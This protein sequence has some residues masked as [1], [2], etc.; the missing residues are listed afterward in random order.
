MWERKTDFW[1]LKLRDQS[2]YDGID[3]GLPPIKIIVILRLNESLDEIL[4]IGVN[5]MVTRHLLAGHLCYDL[6]NFFSC[7]YF[8]WGAHKRCCLCATLTLEEIENLVVRPVQLRWRWTNPFLEWI[9][10][11]PFFFWIL[12]I[13]NVSVNFRYLLT[14][15]SWELQNGLY[16]VLWNKSASNENNSKNW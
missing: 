3:R 8:M 5:Q 11:P 13:V 6:P 16:C 4:P 2:P 15:G 9:W 12:F 10:K 1:K 7:D 14:D